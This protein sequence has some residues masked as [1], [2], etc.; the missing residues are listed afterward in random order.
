MLGCLV[1]PPVCTPG[2]ARMA[3]GKMTEL[4]GP[5]PI[6]LV[7]LTLER[8]PY[9]LVPSGFHREQSQSAAVGWFG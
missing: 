6:S 3:F 8:P 9:G 2:V 7:D 1:S 5:E 4:H